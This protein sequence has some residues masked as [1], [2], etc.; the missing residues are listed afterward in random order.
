MFVLIFKMF[1]AVAGLA[2]NG[3]LLLLRFAYIDMSKYSWILLFIGG[4]IAVASVFGFNYFTYDPEVMGSFLYC[5]G[6]FFIIGLFCGGL[7]AFVPFDLY[8]K[9]IMLING[10]GIHIPWSAIGWI[11]GY[12]ITN[13][14]LKAHHE[15][16]RKDNPPVYEPTTYR[17]PKCFGTLSIVEYEGGG[18][19]DTCNECGY[20]YYHP[21]PINRGNS[22]YEPGQGLPDY[23]Q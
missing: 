20:H 23:F 13:T 10:N 7:I 18:G 11:S 14:I 21:A 16:K 8:T 6:Y 17:C 5:M 4:V 12:F 3:L 22:D 15:K 1:P 9:I 19:K 2:V